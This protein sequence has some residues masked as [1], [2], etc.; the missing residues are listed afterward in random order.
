[1]QFYV[2]RSDLQCGEGVVKSMMG[3]FT[4]KV[5]PLGPLLGSSRSIALRLRFVRA[6]GHAVCGPTAARYYPVGVTF[7]SLYSVDRFP[8]V[9]AARRAKPTLPGIS[10]AIGN[11]NSYIHLLCVFCAAFPVAR[12][13]SLFIF[14]P[15]IQI[16]YQPHPPLPPAVPSHS[17]LGLAAWND[18]T[19]TCWNPAKKITTLLS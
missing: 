18:L 17:T 3:L 7:Y 14:L 4:R 1:M 5:G 10:A 2:V 8:H 13:W 12:S 19:V 11:G 15:S 6:W 9:D 16:L